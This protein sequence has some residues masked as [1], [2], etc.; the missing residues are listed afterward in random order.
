MNEQKCCI[1]G[2]TFS[3]FGN[4]PA[5]VKDNG[6][7][8]Y[9]CNGNVV[10]PA[11]IKATYSEKKKETFKCCFCGDTFNDFAYSAYP[12]MKD[13]KCC[14]DCKN[15]IVIPC[16]FL[17]MSIRN[18][19]T[20]KDAIINTIDMGVNL[21]YCRGLIDMAQRLNAITEKEKDELLKAYTDEDSL[22]DDEA[23]KD[24]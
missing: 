22:R 23:W 18:G 21:Y 15:D 6:V 14:L 13:G 16:R 17:G 12:A 19:K 20:I 24:E 8:C 11:R 4:N 3:G 1:C 9:E 10:I 7:C 2:K 5:P